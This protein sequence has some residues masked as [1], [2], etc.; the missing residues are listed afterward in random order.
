MALISVIIPTLN[1]E[2]YIKGT[3]VSVG[4]HKVDSEIEIIVADGGSEDETVAVASSLAKVVHCPKG[5]AIQLNKAV[6]HSRGE[7][8]F[9]V[10]ADMLLPKETMTHIKT[11]INDEGYDGGG[12]SN[13]F[14]HHN[15]RIKFLGRLLN[16]RM[17]DNDTSSNITF[18][19]DNGI[20]VKR[21]VFDALGGFKDIPI[22]E[23][24]DFSKRL[25]R[26]FRS[27]RIEHPRLIV[28]PRRHE[29]TGFLRTRLQWILIKRLFQVGISPIFLSKFYKS[30][31]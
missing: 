5:R 4:A 6:A 25:A 11:K 15:Q 19:G 24:Y 27:V 14:T 3:L 20:F 12:F 22:M 2:K 16:L 21:Q 13:T 8:L 9:F 18:F 1:E 17:R 23:D 29:K 31:R 10:H 30:V 28:S 7:I 26:R